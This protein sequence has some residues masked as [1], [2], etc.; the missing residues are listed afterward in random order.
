MTDN[1]THR[2]E[3]DPHPEQGWGWLETAEPAVLQAFPTNNAERHAH[4]STNEWQWIAHPPA[5]IDTAAT[6]P[7]R[8][9]L[10]RRAWIAVVAALG[11]AGVLVVAGIVSIA[12]RDYTAAVIPTVTASPPAATSTSA[13]GACAGLSG[14]TVTD[15][16]GDT[17]SAAGVIAAFEHAYYVQRDHEAALRLVAPEIGIVP[18]ALAVGIASIPAGTTHCVAI[19]PIAPGTAEVHLVELHPNGQRIDYLQLINLAHHPDRGAMVITNI[20]KRG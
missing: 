2:Q 13:V 17:G 1:H 3:A 14:Q 5:A 7:R 19:T 11:V 16:A 6:P 9:R 18:E 12:D 8:A 10:P 4:G 20:Q 15:G